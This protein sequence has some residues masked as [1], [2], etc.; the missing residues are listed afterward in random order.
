MGFFDGF[1]GD[2]AG[3]A[4][5]LIGASQQ[6]S[7][8]RG[9]ADAQMQFQSQS[10][11]KAMAFS[12]QMASTAHQREVEDLRKAGLNPILSG[13]GGQ[14]AASPQGVSMPGAQAPVQNTLSALANSAMNMSARMTEAKQRDLIAE[15]EHKTR[16]EA[17]ESAHNA[18]NIQQDSANKAKTYDILD[19][20]LKQELNNTAASALNL[21]RNQADLPADLQHSS[22]RQRIEKIRA[23]TAPMNEVISTGGNA[24]GAATSALGLPKLYGPQS[25]TIEDYHPGTGEVYR[26][27]TITK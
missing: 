10:A 24:I 11:D 17:I 2:I 12:Q 6:N 5:G 18:V 26:G 21:R 19:Q 8:A 15:Q 23:I 13:L 22:N 7:A 16:N 20:Q 14:G 4:L 3:G 25:T 27:R 1:A 9:M